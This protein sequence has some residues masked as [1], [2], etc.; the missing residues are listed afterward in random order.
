MKIGTIFLA[1]SAAT[2]PIASSPSS[3]QVAGQDEFATGNAFVRECPKTMNSKIGCIAFALGVFQGSQ[4]TKRTVCLRPG[5][6]TGQLY[7][8]GIAYIGAH[9]E[10]SDLPPVFLLI[11][12][13]TKTFPCA[14]P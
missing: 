5:V 3:A 6:D 8:V 7:Q 11:E 1:L 2:A 9:P 12:A 4:A 14:A 10:K 13:W